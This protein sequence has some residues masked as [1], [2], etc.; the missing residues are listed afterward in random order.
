MWKVLDL[1]IKEGEDHRAGLGKWGPD[2]A[3]GPRAGLLLLLA[4]AVPWGHSFS[5]EFVN[6][7]FE[8]LLTCGIGF[9]HSK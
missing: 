6:I 5:W 3:A 7:F 8:M 4:K 9:I 2:P 1:H